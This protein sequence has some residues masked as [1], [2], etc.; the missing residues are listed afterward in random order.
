M[1]FP[2]IL[3]SY[4]H[5]FGMQIMIT[6]CSEL[7]NVLTFIVYETV[8]KS[9]FTF[10]FLWELSCTPVAI[11]QTISLGR[12]SLWEVFYSRPS[13]PLE[14]EVYVFWEILD[15]F[16]NFKFIDKSFFH[17][18]SLQVSLFF[19]LQ[20]LIL[21]GKVNLHNPSNQGVWGRRIKEFKTMLG[22]IVNLGPAWSLWD[23][24][25]EP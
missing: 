7:E 2:V 9:K 15:C 1:S 14:S 17:H 8:L 20:S 25:T 12:L 21:V 11:W 24:V 18:I 16:Y 23:P 4:Y 13:L 19:F 3:F 22:Y 10:F 6:S 5:W